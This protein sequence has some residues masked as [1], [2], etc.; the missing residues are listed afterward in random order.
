MRSLLPDTAS[1]VKST[2][3]SGR[4][5]LSLYLFT[6]AGIIFRSEIAILLATTTIYHWA[7]AGHISLRREIIPAGVV[8]L[9]VGLTI[10][11]L[12]DSFFWQE[13]YLWPELASF[14][15]N[16]LSGHASEWG[17]QPWHFYFANAVPRLLLNPL[18]YLICIPLA[19]ARSPHSKAIY[20]QLLPALTYIAIHSLQPHKEWRF[21]I[22]AIPSLTSTAALGASYIWTHRTKSFIYRL[23]S[24][25]LILSTL[26]TFAISSFILLPIS[27]ANYPGAHAL[28]SVHRYAH[29]SKSMVFVHLDNLTC[30]T[31]VT[32]FLEI[33]PPRS[34][35][36]IT[37]KTPGGQTP[38]ERWSSSR[39]V[40]DRTS[41]DEMKR[42]LITF[43][44][45]DY[46]LVEDADVLGGDGEWE[47][48]KDVFGFGGVKVL[49]PGDEGGEHTAEREFIH[50]LFGSSGVRCWEEVV[51]GARKYVTRG[52]WVEASMVPRIKVMKH[53]KR[54][55]V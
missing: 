21:I 32:H 41:H 53:V 44:R 54:Q 15:Y 11:V 2:S 25:A 5:R 6:I 30:Q 55:F 4:Y 42:R 8:G 52:W 19:C 36:A 47:N 26:A 48:I 18:T 13:S 17:V 35:S 39:W 1:N 9:L 28:N 27:M 3:P 51:E 29:G 49:R 23:I 24:M 37:P 34:L 16:I 50:R 22:Y 46:A 14:K 12:I 7:V 45:F 33:A 10:T 20:A 40:Y 31:G 38:G 43:E